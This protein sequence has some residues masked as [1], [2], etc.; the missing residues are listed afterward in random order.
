VRLKRSILFT[1]IFVL[2]LVATDP[3]HAPVHAQTTDT[4]ATVNN[5]PI[6]VAQFQQ[7]VRFARWS[8]A[9]Q[10]LQIVQQ[11]GE[12]ALTDPQ[13]PY[14]AQLKTLAD[15]AAFGQQVLDG[16]ITI[17]LVQQEADK[18]GITVSDEE[19]Q[20][21]VYAFFGY[22]RN[23]EPQQPVAGLPTPP[24][25]TQIAAT[26]AE[27]RDNYFGQAGSIAQMGQPEVLATFTEQVLQVKVYQAVTGN[28][29][30][31]AE[32]VKVRH[33]LADTKAN[34]N[35][36]LALIQGGAKFEEVAQT[37]SID[38]TSAALGGDLGWSPKDT[39]LSEIDTAIW[40]APIGQVIGPIKS[41]FGYHLLL[42]EAHQVRVFSDD[43]LARVR[44]RYYQYWLGSARSAAAIQIV[45]KWQQFIPADPQLTELGLPTVN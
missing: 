1:L 6:S 13:S 38:S 22:N 43:A 41:A 24:D 34:A 12:A 8:T 26:F 44:E 32:Q 5:M 23:A 35:A 37:Y 40:S 31:E 7:R 33:I 10:L 19:T 36:W 21:Q 45:D 11:V 2:T 42:V 14:Y 4:I 15:N 30:T 18:R 27:H 3:N 28:V 17:K 9:Q 20:Q 39:Y 25:P 29:P 16:L